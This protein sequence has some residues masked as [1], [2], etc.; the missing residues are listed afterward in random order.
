MAL[1]EDQVEDL[2]DGGEP[3]GPG[4]RAGAGSRT[5]FIFC[6]A[7]LMRCAMVASGTRYARAISA[8]V[9][10]PTARRVSAICAAAVSCGMAA[11]E[12]QGEGVV[13]ARR[14]VRAAAR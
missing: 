12:Q 7:R 13:L 3:S 11:Q 5:P 4:R 10:P 2:E 1:V 14:A 8:V 6:L 9:S